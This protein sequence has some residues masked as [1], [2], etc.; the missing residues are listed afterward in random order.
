[1]KIE[2]PQISLLILLIFTVNCGNAQPGVNFFNYPQVHAIHINFYEP[3]FYD[4]LTYYKEQGDLTGIEKY[5]GADVIIN[6][7][8]I[9]NVGIRF[10]GNASYNHPGTKKPVQLDFNEFASGQDYDN[11]KKLNLS[12]GYLD[13]S[14]IREKLFMD[15]MRESGM[16]APRVTFSA[17]YFNGSYIGLYKAMETIN[18]D[19]LDAYYNDTDGNLY[20]CEP[21]MPLI[22]E[23]AVQDSYYDNAELKTNETANDWT[24]L[25]D[26]LQT[27]NFSGNNFEN[28]IR[29]DFNLD[30]YIKAWA[31]NNVFGN[32]DSYVYL[33]HNYYLYHN[34]ATD[35]FEWITWDASLAF[36]VYAFLVVP[37]SIDFDILYLPNDAETTRPLNYHILTDATLKQ[38]YMS[39]VCS[40]L[41][42]EMLPA[43]FFPRIDSLGDLIR[44]FVNTEPTANQ[45]F[46]LD[47]FN[48]NLEYETVSFQLIGQIPGLKDFIEKRRVGIIKQLCDLN[49]SCTAGEQITSNQVLNIYPNPGSE[50]TVE[51]IAPNEFYTSNFI[52]F[53]ISGKKIMEFSNQA[54]GGQQQ[55]HLDN[56]SEGMYFLQY[57]SGCREDLKKIVVI[58]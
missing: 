4:S 54:L 25:V 50:I 21:N 41:K 53:D 45:M 24:D 16:A 34:S 6:S 5:I 22:W 11:L 3:A 58:R 1:M 40:F 8:T 57:E 20:K 39:E 28:D 13:P 49:W 15:L 36:G 32:L 12:N 42:N 52:L 9:T 10:R 2:F 30:P 31:A 17:V 43:K 7:D 35:K 33:P 48:E 27:V 19:F 44:P 23:G 14:Q 47:E 46:T 51:T 56:L 26:L 18:K 37:N 38:Q 29:N 55:L